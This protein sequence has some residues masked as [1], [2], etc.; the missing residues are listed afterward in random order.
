MLRIVK[1]I[2][3]I[4]NKS[5][6]FLILISTIY[7]ILPIYVFSYSSQTLSSDDFNPLDEKERTKVARELGDYF[8]PMV[9]FFPNLKKSDLDWIEKESREIR[10]INDPNITGKRFVRLY[11]STEYQIKKIKD[12]LHQIIQS[13]EA[14]LEE[15]NKIEKEMFLWFCVSRKLV[16]NTDFDWGIKKLIDEKILPEDFPQKVELFKAG[17]AGYAFTLKNISNDIQ[18]KIILSYLMQH[19]LDARKKP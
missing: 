3:Y 16:E 7:I 19:S 6:V 18:D 5:T 13:L 15:N 9:N 1:M 17:N 2:K 14:I 11:E 4:F 8:K 10:R 12:Q